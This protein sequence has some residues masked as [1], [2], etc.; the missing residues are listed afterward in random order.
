MTEADPANGLAEVLF[1][2]NNTMDKTW[3]IIAIIAQIPLYM[4]LVTAGVAI[5]LFFKEKGLTFARI[6]LYILVLMFIAGFSQPNPD[7]YWISGIMG[8]YNPVGIMIDESL[9]PGKYGVLVLIALNIVS[10]F[11]VRWN[12]RKYSWLKQDK[13]STVVDLE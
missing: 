9:E 5:N 10:L 6:F 1:V 4:F 8:M 3:T 7:L 13:T 2:F 12:T 11:V